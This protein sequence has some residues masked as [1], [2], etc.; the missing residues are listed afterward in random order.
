VELGGA[1]ILV[2]N[3]INDLKRFLDKSG[4][5]LVGRSKSVCLAGEGRRIKK[6]HDH[7]PREIEQRAL[8]AFN[9][10]R[11]GVIHQAVYT[12]RLAFHLLLALLTHAILELFHRDWFVLPWW[13]RSSGFDMLNP[14]VVYRPTKNEY[15]G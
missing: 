3:A 13:W 9:I 7:F 5:G 10:L 8:S 11:D 4:D 15:D 14:C 6:S 1:P 12:L 2:E